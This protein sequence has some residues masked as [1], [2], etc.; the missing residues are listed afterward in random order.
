MA[1]QVGLEPT[2]QSDSG[3]DAGPHAQALRGRS[4]RP[5][6][7]DSFNTRFLCRWSLAVC[8]IVTVV[9][10]LFTKLK[11]E[12]ELKALVYGATEIPSEGRYPLFHRPIFWAALVGAL[13]ILINVVLW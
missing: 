2:S 5:T 1:P 7:P 6:L 12:E 4:A 13:F 8:V 9:I 10:S 11:P 3:T